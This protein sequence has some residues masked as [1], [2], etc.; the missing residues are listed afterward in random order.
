MTPGRSGSNYSATLIKVPAEV[1]FFFIINSTCLRVLYYPC[2]YP[3]P[4]G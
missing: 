1:F 4:A 3:V 2:Y